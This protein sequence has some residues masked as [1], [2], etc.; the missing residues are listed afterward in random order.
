MALLGTWIAGLVAADI[1]KAIFGVGLFAVA[2]SFL[3]APEPRDIERMDEAIEKEYGGEKAET[4]LIT[5]AGEKISYRVCNRTEGR[6]LAGVGALFIGMISTGLG[7]LNGYFL[8]QRCRVPSRV[9]VAS[10][11]FV[12]AITALVASTG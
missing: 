4:F 12:V 1:L 3:R 2:A 7:E 10:S 9:A 8:L 6:T 11:V 5:R